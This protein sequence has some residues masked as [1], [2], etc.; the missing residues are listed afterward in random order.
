MVAD[1]TTNLSLA[2]NF[3]F[4]QFV[5]I[6]NAI[7]CYVLGDLAGVTHQRHILC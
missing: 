3:V 4:T 6:P 5:S 2:C 1:G 7:Q